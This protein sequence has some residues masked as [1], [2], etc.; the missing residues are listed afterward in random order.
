MQYEGP[1]PGIE[2]DTLDCINT[3]KVY[4]PFSSFRGESRAQCRSDEKLDKCEAQ[5]DFRPEDI[6]AGIIE[7]GVCTAV[8]YF[9][10]IRA[11]ATC[12]TSPSQPIDIE[13]DRIKTIKDQLNGGAQDFLTADDV[14]SAGVENDDNLDMDS[15]GFKNDIINAVK[16]DLANKGN[17]GIFLLNNINSYVIAGLLLVVIFIIGILCGILCKWNNDNKNKEYLAVNQAS[18]SEYTT[19]D[20]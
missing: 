2:A 19:D 18:S 11:I 20:V 15:D 12:C 7:N 6:L 17:K 3:N 14:I 13:N 8:G 4:G 1:H 9:G 5:Y 10:S 16:S